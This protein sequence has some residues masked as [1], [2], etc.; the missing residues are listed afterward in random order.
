M[1]GGGPKTSSTVALVAS[2]SE[3]DDGRVN[4]EDKVDIL[5]LFDI[6]REDEMAPLV[7]P[8]DE[9]KWKEEEKLREE[10]ERARKRFG[11]GDGSRKGK[12]RGKLE[13]AA[14]GGGPE[15]SNNAASADTPKSK[16]DVDPYDEEERIAASLQGTPQGSAPAT[17]TTAHPPTD[18]AGIVVAD[19]GLTSAQEAVTLGIEDVQIKVKKE[20][21]ADYFHFQGEEAR[22]ERFYVFQFP[23]VFPRFF[24]PADP[25]QT[26]H[27]PREQPDVQVKTEDTAA[28]DKKPS[29]SKLNHALAKG[30][31]A[32]GSNAAVAFSSS[33]GSK[34]S[35]GGN[36][37]KPLLQNPYATVSKHRVKSA[38]H[39][40]ESDSWRDYE[41]GKWQ[42]W[43]RNSGTGARDAMAGNGRAEGR[44]GKLRIR[45]SGKV[46]LRLGSGPDKVDYEILPG[47][48]AAFLQE[49]AVLSPGVTK[50]VEQD[51]QD[52]PSN[53][54]SSSKQGGIY[55]MGQLSKKFVIAPDLTQLLRMDANE[56]KVQYQAWK[57]QQ[58]E[59]NLAAAKAKLEE[60]DAST[61]PSTSSGV[62]QRVAAGGA[63]GA[64]GQARG[65]GTGSTAG[66]IKRTPS[67][68]AGAS[69]KK[70]N[71]APPSGRGRGRPP[72]DPSKASS[73]SAPA[74]AAPKKASTAS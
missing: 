14:E 26:K 33:G 34:A 70:A 49:L 36:E 55:V 65:R 68:T 54:D 4:G 66:T 73:G 29:P 18:H 19:A 6:G 11:G 7:L 43:G 48:P 47:A 74:S 37:E 60:M 30:S 10:N 40:S 13:D 50:N 15:D 9:K 1:G 2:D 71:A 23:R 58:Q 31:A 22:Q 27:D 5:D 24:D 56:K 39:E 20:N 51:P 44:I 28:Q 8:R 52:D 17:P 46:T 35:Q 69:G 59:L 64:P 21:V 63:G 53:I 12:G 32:A 62:K 16:M 38:L 41:P 72:G 42:G 25:L 45:R 57:K 67:T 3:S 61:T